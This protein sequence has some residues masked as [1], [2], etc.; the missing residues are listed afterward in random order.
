MACVAE[1][2]GE[3]AVEAPDAPSDGV[4]P[5]ARCEMA[6]HT[7]TAHNMPWGR[8]WVRDDQPQPPVMSVAG[9]FDSPLTQVDM[10]PKSRRWERHARRLRRLAR[11]C[12]PG[13]ELK[14]RPP[15][16]TPLARPS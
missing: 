6:G 3:K 16:S 9:E 7:W 10:S 5:V 11:Q 1:P 8:T 12:R 2:P 4:L 15:V 13:D 14:I